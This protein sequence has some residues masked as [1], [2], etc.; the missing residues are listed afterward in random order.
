M[1][2]ISLW[3]PWATLWVLQIKKYETRSWPFPLKCY[4]PIAIHAAKKKINLSDYRFY[5]KLKD[6]GFDFDSLQYGC[7]IGT[8]I[9]IVP[10]YISGPQE[11]EKEDMLGDWSIGRYYWEAV[12]MVPLKIPIP[13]RGSQGIFKVPDNIFREPVAEENQ[14]QLNLF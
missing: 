12:E 8:C 14:K 9:K 5:K 7:L 3:Q 10:H 13:Y 2:A 4:G 6:D 11:D 1:K